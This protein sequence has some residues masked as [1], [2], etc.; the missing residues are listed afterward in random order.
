LPNSLLF[1]LQNYNAT[2]ILEMFSQEKGLEKCGSGE[3]DSL[4]FPSGK[5]S[6]SAPSSLE[7]DQ[8]GELR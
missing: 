5:L 6:S 4:A 1:S 7:I 3:R 8:K 2:S